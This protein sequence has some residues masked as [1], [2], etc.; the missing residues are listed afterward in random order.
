MRILFIAHH[1]QPEPNFFVGLPFAKELVKRGHSIQV[2]T[3]FPNY[4]GGKIYDGY[5]VKFLQ[6]EVME[7]IPVIR[8]PL[9]PSHDNSALR[10]TLTYTS[11][12]LS[13]SLVGPCV[14]SSADV[15]YV[16]QGPATVG[17]PSCVMQILRGI[18]K[19]GY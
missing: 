7:G 3:G 19:Q 10:R 16:D 1:F 2:L 14:V 9:Y 11:Y 8:V 17:L 15:A 18:P 12:A 6:R 5:T 4:P 13:A